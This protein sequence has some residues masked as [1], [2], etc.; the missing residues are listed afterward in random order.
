MFT[1]VFVASPNPCRRRSLIM[2][3]HLFSRINLAP[4]KRNYLCNCFVYSDFLMYCVRNERSVRFIF[5]VHF[6][7]LILVS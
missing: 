2:L 6:S 7:V 5:Y 3:E 1:A 4:N